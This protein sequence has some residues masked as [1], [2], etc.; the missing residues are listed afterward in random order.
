M[1]LKQGHFEVG[2]AQLFCQPAQLTKQGYGGEVRG[3]LSGR[4]AENCEAYLGPCDYWL[5]SGGWESL[6][7]S[8]Q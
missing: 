2:A 1:T 5:D 8:A 6:F 7:P 4:S 3:H